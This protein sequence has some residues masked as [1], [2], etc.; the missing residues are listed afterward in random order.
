MP[1]AAHYD[2]AYINVSKLRSRS[3]AHI[4]LYKYEP[5]P[6][7]NG[8]ILNISQIIKFFMS[9]AAEAELTN[10]FFT[11]KDMVPLHQTLIEIKW[12]QGQSPI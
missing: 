11:T 8:P 12:S 1:L 10:L 2:A 6:Q 7:Y 5:K 4:L 9:S 3:R